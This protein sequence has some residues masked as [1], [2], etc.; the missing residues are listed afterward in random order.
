[1][2]KERGIKP[3]YEQKAF[4]DAEKRGRLRVVASPEGRDG[5]VS[6]HTNAVVYAGLFAAG[7]SATLALDHGHG[8]WVHVA[9]GKVRISG[10]DL[11]AGDAVSLDGETT[12]RVEGAPGGNGEVLVFDLA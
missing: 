2:P 12:V 6:I 10:R 8:A 9:R 5:S 3:S 7:E 4:S 11:E 1:M